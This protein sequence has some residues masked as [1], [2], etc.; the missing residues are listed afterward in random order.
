M[1]IPKLKDAT[2]SEISLVITNILVFLLVVFSGEDPTIIIFVFW[3]ETAAIGFYSILKMAAVSLYSLSGKSKSQQHV[4]KSIAILFH[5]PFFT[6][7]FGMFM[8]VHLMFLVVFFFGGAGST[9]GNPFIWF[10]HMVR[11]IYLPALMLFISHGVSFYQNFIQKR[12]YEEIFPTQTIQ[13]MPYDRVVT[14]H[15]LIFVFG[16]LVAITPEVYRAFSASILLAV[17]VFADIRAHRRE[18]NLG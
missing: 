17:K 14:M 13:M 12:E 10:F 18:H 15:I 1:I 5:V 7:H 3:A 11:T 9:D 2:T 4:L 16:F 8:L 6:F